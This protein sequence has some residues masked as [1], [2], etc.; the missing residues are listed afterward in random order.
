[1][2]HNVFGRKLARTASH[3]LAMRRNLVQSLIEHGEIRTTFVKA[4]EVR[5]FAERLATL[6]I[7]GSLAARQRAEALLTDRAI[8]PKENQAEYDRMTDARR[9]KVLRSRSGRRYRTPKPT[10]KLK[11]TATSVLHRLFSDVGPKLKRRNDARG[12]QGGY[13]RIIKLAKRRLGDGG[14]LAILQWVGDGDAPRPKLKD[15]TERRRRAQVRYN[16]Y[17][18][19]PRSERS[20]RR[21]AKPATSAAAGEK[22]AATKKPAAKKSPASRKPAAE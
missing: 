10:A 19:K 17:A 7:D 8:I 4:K 6:A 9:A 20:R 15:K 12:S 14:Q 13:T 22:P 5:R 16:F 18:G 21:A 3:R 11:F 1:M 2:R